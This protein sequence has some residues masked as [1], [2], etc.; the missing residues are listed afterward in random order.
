MSVADHVV[1]EHR[2]WSIPAEQLATGS[3]LLEPNEFAEEPALNRPALRRGRRILLDRGERHLVAAQPYIGRAPA[4][5]RAGD[6]AAP[7]G[8]RWKPKS[9]SSAEQLRPGIG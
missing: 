5:A 4:T 8:I 2:A 9:L 3:G 1:V 6:P 7:D